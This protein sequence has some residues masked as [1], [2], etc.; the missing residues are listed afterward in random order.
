MN[1]CVRR[2]NNFKAVNLTMKSLFEEG[3]V[4]LKMEKRF[5]SITR[6]RLG[7]GGRKDAEL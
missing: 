2:S 5:S 1:R 4:I 7:K 6:I 3:L